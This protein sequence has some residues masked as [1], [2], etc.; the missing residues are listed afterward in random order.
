MSAIMDKRL[1]A[2]SVSAVMTVYVL[3]IVP[4]VAP[5]IGDIGGI[6]AAV[7]GM[8]LS[9]VLWSRIA[10]WVKTHLYGSREPGWGAFAVIGIP[11]GFCAIYGTGAPL[12]F[13]YLD[14]SYLEGLRWLAAI[15]VC[16]GTWYGLLCSM[17]G[18]WN[19]R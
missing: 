5:G 9:A 1:I 11:L 2:C 12:R 13:V 14:P 4:E 10:L 18:S 17:G 16:G 8:W 15:G 7:I 6:L 3:A 19:Q